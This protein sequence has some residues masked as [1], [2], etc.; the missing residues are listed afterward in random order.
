MQKQKLS[1]VMPV[2]NEDR[3]LAAI[4]EKVLVATTLVD[5]ELIVVDD[6]STDRSRD[7]ITQISKS[8]NILFHFQEKNQGKGAAVRK[9]IAMAT[10][11]WILIQDADM[12]YDP[13]DYD[14]LLKPALEGHA[15]AV[16]GSRFTTSEYRRVLY[17][18]HSVAN[19]ALTWITNILNDLTLTDMETCYKLVRADLL[20][21]LALR[22]DSFAI[23]PEITTRL[24]QW[25]ARIYEVPISYRGRTYSEG[26]N[27][28]P[29]DAIQAVASLL[30]CRFVNTK[31][32]Y[33]EQYLTLRALSRAKKFNAMLMG[34]VL[35]FTGKRVL[36]A[37]CGL[38]NLTESLLRK[39]RLVAIDYEKKYADIITSRFGHLANV[40]ALQA[41][42]MD[43]AS[44][45]SL[46][47]ENFDT[48]MCMNVL[49]HIRDDSAVLNSFR[50]ILCPGGVLI[51]LVPQ[52]A[53]LF[54]PADEAVGHFRRYSRKD[55]VSKMAAAGFEVV[56]TFS[57]NRFG[58]LGWLVNSRILKSR[59][60]SNGQ[61]GLFEILMPLVR[62]LEWIPILPGLSCVA[63]GKK[64]N[65]L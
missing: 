41:D 50:G 20:K 42:L 37:G 34:R 48:I 2:Y 16:F 1:V 14:R 56:S 4:I 17:Y 31:F 51:C 43:T 28:G 63:V 47:S 52:H 30:Y 53:W 55:L 9:G 10:G 40:R 45:E 36:E 61:I 18:W 8:K 11:H 46:R 39:E 5:I 58:V 19:K 38:G 57:F 12:E 22:A 27:I 54:G 60:I 21:Q 64:I 33:D 15:D 65:V 26:K 29:A 35:P 6:G 24:A 49:E 23:E 62:L 32:T 44:M 13:A 7:I 3:T 25:G 59:K